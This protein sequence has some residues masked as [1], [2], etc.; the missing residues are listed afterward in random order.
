MALGDI[1]PWLNVQP[2]EFVRAAQMGAE[3]GLAARR[4]YASEQEAGDR[5][6]LAYS[7]LASQERQ[8]NERAAAQQEIAAARMQ[9]QMQQQ[10]AA[11]ALREQQMQSLDR[12][13]QERLAQFGIEG[14]RRQSAAEALNQYRQARLGQYQEA[15]E[16]SADKAA[17]LVRSGQATIV[18]H[19]ELPGI[20]FMRNPSGAE[21][22]ITAIPRSPTVVID[23]ETGLP[24][25]ISGRLEDPTI[26]GILGTN[27]PG[28]RP[29][30]PDIPATTAPSPAAATLQL[31]SAGGR[32][33]IG[34]GSEVIRMTKDG[35]RA[36]FDAKTQQ[37]LRYADEDA[38]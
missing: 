7:Q 34:P 1:P 36:V 26:R 13:R 35:R 22:R 16:I 25:T 11:Q 21:Y 28:Y 9:M 19:P 38:E 18:E 29:T 37:F 15:L 20:K 10:D 12:Y 4:Q 3:A 32:L 31:P 17:A 14:E 2:S 8:A 24:K 5:L 23:A 30:L 27:A 6:R 33:S